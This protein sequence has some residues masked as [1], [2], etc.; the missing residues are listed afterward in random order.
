LISESR[1]AGAIV[2]EFVR[3]CGV[4][5]IVQGRARALELAGVRV[6]VFNSG[7]RFVALGGRCPHTGG[8][9]GHGWIEDGEAVCPLHHWRFRLGD[10][11]CTSVSGE[12]VHRFDCEVR[13]DEVWVAV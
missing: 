6:A 5:E 11:R 1:Q 8:P 2:P 4:D 12:S 7:G 3:A 10:G 13:G 9:L